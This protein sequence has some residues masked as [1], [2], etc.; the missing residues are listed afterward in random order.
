MIDIVETTMGRSS[1]RREA[2]CTP[3]CG[4]RVARYSWRTRM[5][6]DAMPSPWT[7]APAIAGSIQ[8]CSPAIVSRQRSSRW[9]RRQLRRLGR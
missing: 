7:P 9:T 1:Q 5:A 8:I 2:L 6:L 4:P 3:S